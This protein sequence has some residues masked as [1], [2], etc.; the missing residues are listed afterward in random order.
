MKYVSE[1]IIYIRKVVSRYFLNML[2]LLVNVLV[3]FYTQY[4]TIMFSSL[5]AIT[6]STYLYD[7][8]DANINMK[9]MDITVVLSILLPIAFL[10]FEHDHPT[11]VYAG[12]ILLWALVLFI[13]DRLYTSPDQSYIHPAGLLLTPLETLTHPMNDMKVMLHYLGA[14]GHFVFNVEWAMLVLL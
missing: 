2:L 11:R 6:V 14:F 8:N 7:A 1:A 5:A 13:A 4:Y 9:F 3:G 12:L 10:W